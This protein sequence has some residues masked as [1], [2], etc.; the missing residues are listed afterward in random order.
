MDLLVKKPIERLMSEAQ[1][2]QDGM[3]RVLGPGAL[4][5][6]GVGVIIGAGL[7]SVTGVVAGEHTGPAI[8]LSFLIAAVACAFAGLCYAEFASMLPVAGSAYTYSYVT[9]GEL[10]A[11]IIG[12]DLVLEYVVAGVTVRI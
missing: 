7:F 12:W 4:I 8:C 2:G 11:W 3:R 9:M 6:L 1:G 10:V 5:A